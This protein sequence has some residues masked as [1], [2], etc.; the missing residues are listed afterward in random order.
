MAQER[1]YVVQ[2]SD[3]SLGEINL[4]NGQVDTHVLSLGHL[5]NDIVA[6]GSH[7]YVTNSG[8]NT[9]QEIDAVTNTTLREIPV[10][11]GANPYSLAFINDDTLAVTN[12][13]SNNVVLLRLSDGA[14]VGTIPVGLGPEGILVHDSRLFVCLTRYQTSGYGP[15]VVMVYDRSTLRLLDS[16]RVGTNPQ[17][18]QVDDR[19]RLHVV[20]T[21]NYADVPGQ[22]HVVNLETLHTDTVL[23]VGGTPGN[24]SF[25]GGTAFVAA[26]GWGGPGAVFRY[27]LDDLSILNS[28]ANPI[29]VGEGATDVE[30]QPDTT[31]FVSCF[32][33]N[34]VEHRMRDGS[35]ID[36]F[37]MSTGPGQMVLF[38]A[39]DEAR[40]IIG[41]VPR[42]FALTE[43]FPNPFNSAVRLKLSTTMPANSYIL[44][45]NEL[46]RQIAK[47]LVPAGANEI[48]WAPQSSSRSYITSGIYYAIWEQA[49]PKTVQKLVYLK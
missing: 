24:V 10:T 49:D 47:V 45:Y 35:R 9:V 5:C 34:Q 41:P 21:G 4:A 14:Q 11:G 27:R 37:P 12:W 8:L 33:A 48:L 29:P 16:I 28:S 19:N 23:A 40:P 46:G 44:I 17:S 25:G 32:A 2:V 39:P 3:E 1:L 20:C 31:F 18:A 36:V 42:Q 38:G 6:H 7:L 15:G 43:A 22:I 26:G 13:L 30:A